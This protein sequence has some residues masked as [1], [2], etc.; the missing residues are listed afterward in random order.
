AFQKNNLEYVNKHSTFPFTIENFG[1]DTTIN[2]DTNLRLKIIK[3]CV[4]IISISELKKG[5][6]IKT[7]NNKFQIIIKTFSKDG[8]LESE[9]TVVFY[10]KKVN[11]LYKLH[12]ILLTG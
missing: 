5:V 3:E 1:L 4:K 8:E 9:S 6:I 7:S 10:F 11:K 12:K 2:H